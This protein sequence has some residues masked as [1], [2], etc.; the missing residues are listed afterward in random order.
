MVTHAFPRFEGDMAGVFIDLLVRALASRGHEIHVITPSDAGNGGRIDWHGIAVHRV[1]Y[2]PRRFERLAHRGAMVDASRSP[3]GA[4][5][6]LSLVRALR[7]SVEALVKKE[8]LDV[9]HAHWWAPGGVAVWRASGKTRIP[10]V[11]TVHGTDAWLLGRL[12]G[13]SW[14]GRR[15]FGRAAACTAVSRFLADRVRAEVGDIPI[16]VQPMP[17]DTRGF[18]SLSHGGGGVVTIGRLSA[19]KRV[20]DL[21]DAMRVLRDRGTTVPLTII[22]DGVER[23]ALESR[24]RNPD[25][26]VRFVGRVPPTELPERL[27]GMDVC[28]M[29]AEREGLG[30]AAIEALIAGV[31]VVVT[32]EG[33]GLLDIVGEGDHGRVVPARHPEALADAIEIFLDNPS[34][35]K[36]AAAAGVGWRAALDPDVVAESFER[37]YDSVARQVV[38]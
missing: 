7:L 33:G 26:D 37:T 5:T 14:L 29:P 4:L 22:G 10:Y 13:A 19:Q 2:A 34:A 28:V 6:L 23:A 8:G 31:P 15:V 25:I 17:T 12:P 11:V 38:S 16:V 24:A 36:A 27:G 18:V 3:I 20:G 30:L 35:R 9:V 1:R 21:I 32:E